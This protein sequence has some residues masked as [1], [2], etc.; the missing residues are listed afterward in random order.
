[1]STRQCIWV[2][3]AVVVLCTCA[4]HGKITIAENGEAN[5][6]IVVAAEATE[7][8]QHAAAELA[9]FLEQITGAVSRSIIE[10]ALKKAL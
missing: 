10:N 7:P 9:H 8:E 4:S 2:A 1:M 6:L 3:V 5:A